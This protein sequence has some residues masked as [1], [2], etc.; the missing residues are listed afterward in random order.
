MP[1][2]AQ[3]IR[4]KAITT[5]LHKGNTYRTQYISL[6]LH[7]SPT[8]KQSSFSF[9]VSKKVEKSAVV[10][11]TLKKR[12]RHVLRELHTIKT[13]SAVFFMK[14]GISKLSF[15]ELKNNIILLLKKGGVLLQGKI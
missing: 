2:V 14:K 3:T 9:V 13:F 11:N 1:K 10:R 8:N 4:R 7:L 15:S 5:V 6:V 12:G